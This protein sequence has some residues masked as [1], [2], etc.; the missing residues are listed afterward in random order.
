M[1]KRVLYF[2]CL[3][4]IV[5]SCKKDDLTG[6]SNSSIKVIS[7]VTEPKQVKLVSS[8]D[9]TL[10]ALSTSGDLIVPASHQELILINAG[11][12][13]QRRISLS[14]TLFQH[15]SAVRGING[16]FFVCGT[17]NT[18]SYI[19]IYYLD[20]SGEKLWSKSFTV[21]FGTS[22]NEPVAKISPDNYYQVMYQSYGSGYYIW[23]GDAD[24]NE[25]SNI[26][27]PTPNAVHYGSGLNYG[28][29]YSDFFQVNDTL[30]IAQGITIDR[31]ESD[32]ENCFLRAVN[33][34]MVKKWYSD[35]YD[36]THMESGA[37]LAYINDKIILFGSKADNQ[38]YEYYGDVFARTYSTSGDFEGEIV[39]PKVGGSDTRI[40]QSTPSP[41]GG[42]LLVGSN[43][44]YSQGELVSPNNIVLIKLD[45]NAVFNWARS[46]ETDSPS[47]GFDAVYLADGTIGLIGLLKEKEN[48]NKI[49]YMH[50]DASG[51]IVNN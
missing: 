49:V 7:T 38:Y 39:Y 45:H 30:I 31:Y 35:N 51:V 23:K 16:G 46:I 8:N 13:V 22:L 20:D 26:K 48:A 37:G 14:D 36:S 40:R 12:V 11:G 15:M 9:G 1:L 2:F 43:N 33:E 5:F 32:I 42:F 27:F 17:S 4:S 50:L 18:F 21:K 47:K 44:Q 24:G 10:L 29:R 41:D 25:V 28:E 19:A 6:G 3:A 34:N